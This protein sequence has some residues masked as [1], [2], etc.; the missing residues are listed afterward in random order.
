M[1]QGCVFGL[2]AAYSAVVSALVSV[3]VLSVMVRLMA[4]VSPGYCITAI[5][6]VNEPVSVPDNPVSKANVAPASIRLIVM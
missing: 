2:A 1:A 3:S 4:G 6:V 5:V